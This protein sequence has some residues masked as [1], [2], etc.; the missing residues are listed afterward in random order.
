MNLSVHLVSEDIQKAFAVQKQIDEFVNTMAMKAEEEGTRDGKLHYHWL[1]SRAALSGVYLAE[2]GQ[3]ERQMSDERVVESCHKA[4][5][6]VDASLATIQGEEAGQAGGAFRWGTPRAF[7]GRLSEPTAL[8]TRDLRLTG[9]MGATFL[10][11]MHESCPPKSPRR[12][13]RVTWCYHPRNPHLLTD[14]CQLAKHFFQR[15][16]SYS[17]PDPSAPNPNHAAVLLNPLNENLRHLARID[18]LSQPPST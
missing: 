3:A 9:A 15:A 11:L 5:E 16:V 18:P 17:L 10:G 2:M 4:L 12:D 14:G 13:P 7:A 1:R 6:I 8:L